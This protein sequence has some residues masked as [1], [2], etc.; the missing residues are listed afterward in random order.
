VLAGACEG[1]E[2]TT[3]DGSIVL[4]SVGNFAAAWNYYIVSFQFRQVE[5]NVVIEYGI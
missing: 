1:M 3:I 2:R 5:R 4:E